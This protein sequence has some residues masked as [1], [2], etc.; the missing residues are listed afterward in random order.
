MATPQ[1]INPMLTDVGLDEANKAERNGYQL[2]ITHVALGT[3]KYNS[4]T[5]GA[6]MTALSNMKEY[7]TIAAGRTSGQHG[8]STTVEFD[9]YTGTPYEA[10][11]I[12]FYSGIPG[13]GG[14]LVAVYSHPSEALVLRNALR[15]L[16]TFIFQ[17]SRLPAG[18]INVTI[19][20][21]ASSAMALIANHEAATDPHPQYIKRSGDTMQGALKGI[22]PE[23]GDYSK[24]FATTEFFGDQGLVFPRAG[25]VGTEAAT[26][27]TVAN[28][29]RVVNVATENAVITLP[30]TSTVPVGAS[31]MIRCVA[32]NAKIVVQGSDLLA[33]LGSALGGN[34][35]AL[36]MQM[37]SFVTLVRNEAR[38]WYVCQEG[39]QE[40]AGKLAYFIGL[41][42]PAGWFEPV[43]QLLSRTAYARLWA[44]AQRQGV[45][46][47][48]SWASFRGRFSSGTD[49]TNFRSPDLRGVFLR[50]LDSGRGL[51]AGRAW[52]QEQDSLNKSHLHGVDDYG[53][54]HG[55]SIGMSGSHA[56]EYW[57]DGGWQR[58]NVA[59][60]RLGGS[61][62]VAFEEGRGN[63]DWPVVPLP[64]VGDHSHAAYIT[65]AN[66]NIYVR[67][68]GGAE[69]RPYNTALKLG[70]KY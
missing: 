61:W 42:L 30:L 29:G 32:N 55:V 56:H 12:G 57:A 43:G 41:S 26:K 36:A 47:D 28:V 38:M 58:P 17:Q 34:D 5:L 20:Q 65:A 9:S 62:A 6:A 51:D 4:D 44:Y 19:D 22:T 49:S 13:N 70:L 25:I 1:T 64:F 8:F 69:A 46:A 7:V 54:T 11:E 60:H 14:V 15:Y 39:A 45:V 33:T 40:P 21:N 50:S 16:S 59:Q 37:G 67:N 52:G 24:N 53:H 2:Y 35:T 3:G 68:D 27:L 31:L 63:P 10:C 18:V 48:S 66:S 23:R